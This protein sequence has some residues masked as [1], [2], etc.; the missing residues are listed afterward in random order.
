MSK[1]IHIG[2]KIKEVL[3]Q[4]RIGKTEFAR[5]IN[6]SR[7]VVY[8]IFK[9][10]TIDTAQLQIISKALNH[11]FFSYYNNEPLVL[12]EPKEKV[13][14]VTKEE[15]AQSSRE[16]IQLVKSEFEKLREELSLTKDVYKIPVKKR[17]TKK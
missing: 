3:I 14:Y 8:D 1:H 9:R 10:E 12:K 16:I 15:L 17:S 13:G 2:K 6:V 11:D 5:M 4:S 7:T